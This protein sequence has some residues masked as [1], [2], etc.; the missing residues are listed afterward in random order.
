MS[1]WTYYDTESRRRDLGFSRRQWRRLHRSD[2]VGNRRRTLE[3]RTVARGNGRPP[4]KYAATLVWLLGASARG[5]E[6]DEPVRR[7]VRWLERAGLVVYGCERW[8]LL[9]DRG[10]AVAKAVV[11]EALA[12]REDE[13]CPF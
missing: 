8:W 10:M 7:R 13:E 5:E 2:R 12:R 6:I 3:L 4:A 1:A 9:T 11:A